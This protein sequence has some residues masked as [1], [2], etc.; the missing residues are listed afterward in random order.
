MFYS[1]ETDHIN[2]M[3]SALLSLLT[4]SPRRAALVVFVVAAATIGGAWLFQ[5]AGYYPCELCL[6]ERWP[7]YVGVPLAVL[8]ALVAG[9]DSK[10]LGRA[11]LYVLAL[12]FAGSAIFGIYHAG[13]EWGFWPGPSEC[14][15]AL[16]NADFDSFQQ[17]L[18][19]T[20]VVQC[21]AAAIRIV[22]ISLAGWNALISAALCAIAVAG[23]RRIG[24]G[25]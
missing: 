13:V 21:N 25:K 15:G 9:P 1:V 24:A 18:Q 4:A 17:Q 6:K 20:V 12:I 3:E 19:N 16:N 8:V 11:G 22:G 23:A 7:Y 5:M 2:L 10:G 14:T